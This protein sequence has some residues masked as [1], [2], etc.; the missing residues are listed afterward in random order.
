M[1]RAASGFMYKRIKK[2]LMFVV[3]NDLN[4]TNE[5]RDMFKELDKEWNEKRENKW[6]DET[7]PYS[8]SSYSVLE[9]VEC[10]MKVEFLNHK[11]IVDK[12]YYQF[13]EKITISQ[14][15]KLLNGVCT[16]L[17]YY[18][19]KKWKMHEPNSIYGKKI[20][21]DIAKEYLKEA[22]IEFDVF[23]NIYKFFGLE[24]T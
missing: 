19:V 24:L 17:D 7:F 15:A 13:S 21:G 18:F 22:G 11:D 9:D 4:R 10:M 23:L 2:I 6:F 3:E 1:S 8:F 16:N 14:I 20:I 12:F 5:W